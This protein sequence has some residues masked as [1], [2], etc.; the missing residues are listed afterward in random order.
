MFGNVRPRVFIYALVSLSLPLVAAIV[1]WSVP[2]ATAQIGPPPIVCEVVA[3]GRLPSGDR[4]I[5]NATVFQFGFGD[6]TLDHFTPWEPTNFS[7]CTIGDQALSDLCAENDL[8]G[9]GVPGITR[10]CNR[11]ADRLC[12]DQAPE[13]T[14]CCPG[15]T[16]LTAR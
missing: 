11:Q 3:D 13:N 1:A 9:G 16:A 4:F 7:A 6:G 14:K 10:M 15:A 5:G 8:P 2:R 12:S